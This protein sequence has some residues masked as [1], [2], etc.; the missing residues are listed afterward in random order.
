MKSGWSLL[1]NTSTGL[2]KMPMFF[3]VALL[4]FLCSYSEASNRAGPRLKGLIVV[5]LGAVVVGLLVV[6]ASTVVGLLFV[7]VD[8]SVDRNLSIAELK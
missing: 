3:E 2:S 4:G 6:V 1:W 5:C 7:L 8:L